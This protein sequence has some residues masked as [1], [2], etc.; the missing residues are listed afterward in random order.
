MNKRNGGISFLGALQIALICLKLIGIINCSWFIVLLPVELFL[1]SV[2]I[3]VA[4]CL[5]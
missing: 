4:I 3:L 5:L 1:I 2:A